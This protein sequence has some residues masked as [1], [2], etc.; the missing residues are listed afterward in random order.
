MALGYRGQDSPHFILRKKQGASQRPNHPPEHFEGLQFLLSQG[1]AVL[2][3][4]RQEGWEQERRVHVSAHVMHQESPEPLGITDGKPIQE[5]ESS[6][7]AEGNMNQ[8]NTEYIHIY[9]QPSSC[10]SAHMTKL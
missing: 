9:V 7:T 2:R 5:N 3:H 1:L 6:L 10:I 8:K 4:G